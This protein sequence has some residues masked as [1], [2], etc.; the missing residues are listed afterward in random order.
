MQQKIYLMTEDVAKLDDRT[1]KSNN[2]SIEACVSNRSSRLLILSPKKS[3]LHK[4]ARCLNLLKTNYQ[5]K[6]IMNSNAQELNKN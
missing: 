6:I 3:L 5:P 2:F 4:R 1:M